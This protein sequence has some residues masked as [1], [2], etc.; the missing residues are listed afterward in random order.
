M[1]TDSRTAKR[2]VAGTEQ[3][4]DTSTF[5]LCAKIGAVEQAVTAKLNAITAINRLMSAPN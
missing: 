3:Y 2:A 1:A 4:P 5:A